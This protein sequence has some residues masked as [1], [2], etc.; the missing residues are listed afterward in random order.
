ML[1]EIWE[2]QVF[3][4]SL[5]PARFF[6]MPPAME[7]QRVT[8]I[9]YRYKITRLSRTSDIILWSLTAYEQK[10]FSTVPPAILPP[11]HQ[12]TKLPD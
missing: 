2:N 11:F 10:T 9:S 4:G 8:S 5:E 12:T 3:P 1:S 6:T 7:A